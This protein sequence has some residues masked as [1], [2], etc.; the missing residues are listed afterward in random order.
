MF[1]N[2]I[3]VNGEKPILEVFGDIKNQIIKLL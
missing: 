1:E 3:M 2:V